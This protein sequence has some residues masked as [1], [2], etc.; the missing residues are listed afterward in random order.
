[1]VAFRWDLNPGVS[2]PSGI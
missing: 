1:M 2:I